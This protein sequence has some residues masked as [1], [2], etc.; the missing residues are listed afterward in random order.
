MF[1]EYSNFGSSEFSELRSI[2][3][4]EIG[5]FEAWIKSFDLELWCRFANLL[6]QTV[7]SEHKSID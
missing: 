5:T 2:I 7:T 6:I 4:I 3:N 1:G